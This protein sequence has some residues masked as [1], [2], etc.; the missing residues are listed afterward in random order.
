[1]NKYKIGIDKAV[2]GDDKTSEF[3]KF[4]YIKDSINEILGNIDW[5]VFK[6]EPID[7]E[8]LGCFNVEL[9][10]KEDKSNIWR[11]YIDGASKNAFLFKEYIKNELFEK[12]G[13][14]AE[15]VTEW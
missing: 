8:D 15:I 6:N 7:V 4:K 14:D 1:M 10:T 3:N 12:Y 2:N 9:I 11:A 13:V 5:N